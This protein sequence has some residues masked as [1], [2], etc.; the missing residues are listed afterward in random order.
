MRQPV[1]YANVTT[2]CNAAG[3]CARILA[4]M[5]LSKNPVRTLRS[6]SIGIFGTRP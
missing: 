5:S 2:G 3:K 1:M 4:I 6:F